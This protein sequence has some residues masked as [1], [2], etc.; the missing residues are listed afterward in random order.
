M[1]STP[2]DDEEAADSQTPSLIAVGGDPHGKE[3]LLSDLDT[4]ITPTERFYVR[5][6]FPEAPDLAPST[7]S[8]EI[9]GAVDRPFTI[10]YDELLAMPSVEIVVTMECAGNSRSYVTPPAEGISFKHGAVGT[11]NW[12]GVP[13]PALL[14]RAGLRDTAKEV[15][16][17]G[18]DIGDEEEEGQTIRL[19]YGRSLPVT[20]A[21]SEDTIVAYQMNGEPLDPI[22]GYP[23]RLIAPRWY[24]MAS[25][26][27]LTRVEAL[28]QPYTGFFQKRRYIL[29][30]E[31]EVQHDSWEP[32]STLRVKSLITHPR[33]GEVVRVGQHTARGVAWSGDGDVVKVEASA[34]GGRD[35]QEVS[36]VGPSS[37]TAWRQ[38]EHS[39]SIDKPGH[40]ILMARATDSVG[41]TQPASIPWN[42]RGY[43]NNGIHT[44]AVEVSQDRK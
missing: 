6:H 39:W 14:R 23:V 12:K 34:N 16:L 24:G 33:H 18:A 9:T 22:R 15:L 37:P 13:L 2:T 43:G 44:I 29:I 10:G 25:V 7:Y 38:W 35:W 26:K 42:F 20:D 40:Y 32:L 27:W 19:G 5:S 21:M 17:E 4:W 31:G 30:N 11:A 8:L 41:N 28:E 1:S 36:L 3:T